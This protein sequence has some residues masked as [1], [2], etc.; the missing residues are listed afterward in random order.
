MRRTTLM[1]V[2]RSLITLAAFVL[3]QVAFA[4][5]QVVSD[6]GDNGGANQLRAKLVAAQG[7]GGGTITF[8]CGSATITLTNGVL[9]AI[10]TSIAIDGGNNI[11]LSGYYTRILSIDTG[12]TLY[13]RNITLIYGQDQGAGG[14]IYMYNSTLN[15]S[16][17]IFKYNYANSGYG[18]ALYAYSAT[19]NLTDV[20]FDQ[21]VASRDGGGA[22]CVQSTFTL[23]NVKFTNN[24]SYGLSG[25]LLND[26]G[27]VSWLGGVMS[28]NF[29]AKGGAMS[30]SNNSSDPNLGWSILRGVTIS[31]NSANDLTSGTEPTLG[32]GL[33]VFLGAKLTLINSTV[34]DNIANN[35]NSSGAYGGGI[36]N[37]GVANLTN[38]TLSANQATDGGGGIYNNGGAA[39][40]SNVTIANNFSGGIR[41]AGGT[42]TVKSTLLAGNAPNCIGVSDAGFNMSD[43]NSCGFGG[44]R[45]NVSN[46][47]LGPLADNGGLDPT[48]A[49]LPG[50][51][52]IDKGTS[53]GQTTDQRGVGYAR[54][55]G[56]D[57]D[58]GAFESG[59]H[60]DAVSR[61]VH[62]A[63]P[64]D[65]S[66]PL[67]GASGIECRNGGASGVHQV[68][69]AFPSPVSLT[70]ASVTNGVGS[71]SGA[72]VNGSQVTVNLTEVAN[73]QKII[74]T[75]FDVSDGS[76]TNDINIPMGVLLGDTTGNGTVNAS[77][78]SLTK[79]KSGQTVSASNFRTD[80]TVSNSINSSDVSLVKS[81]S[82]TAL[83]P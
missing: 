74:L 71:A 72:T 14:A 65:I 51:A 11:I 12:G 36:F 68:I 18:G 20:T 43:D 58:V 9:P 37:A 59:A 16:N 25:A 3:A 83:P 70:A 23:K 77:D 27:F 69:V 40:L 45:D 4:T 66:L 8:N 33:Y 1:F 54:A 80:V 50:S 49:L 39:T 73:A 38:V 61:K 30:I 48:I 47:M 67:A 63:T 15:A 22:C 19:A 28:N 81:K 2:S 52:A 56:A 7:S 76:N 32:G 34:Q 26:T 42:M 53:N 6:P 75:L 46:L 5:D 29:A 82:G 31:H 35:P 24:D 55:V 44:T 62:G 21:N 10:T 78:V 79:S 41:N 60:I 57:A 13:L 64:F 17:V